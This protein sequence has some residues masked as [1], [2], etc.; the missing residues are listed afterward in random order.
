[1]V[2]DMR[3]R[4][5]LFVAGLCRSLSK[6]D[7]VSMLIRDM[8]ILRLMIY[9]QQKLKGPTP[10]SSSAPA[11]KNNGEYYR[12]RSRVNP[13]Y[14]QGSM[15]QSGS[16]PPA[17]A[18]CGRNHSV[19]CCEGSADFFKCSLT[20]HFMRECPENMQGNGSGGNKAQSSSVSPPDRAAPRGATSGAGGGT[21]RL[22][23]VN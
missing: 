11:P 5:S 14:S 19:V 3:S 10:S 13:S 17:C 18:K 23:A 20:G 2:K 6:E 1:M 9:V 8:V 16:K 22:Y 7:R 15:A 4:M 12:Q 21:N